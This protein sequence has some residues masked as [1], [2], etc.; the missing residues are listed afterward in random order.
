MES[1][2]NIQKFLA[3]FEILKFQISRKIE[4]LI[5]HDN[6]SDVSANDHHAQSHNAA[7]HSDITSSGAVIEAA[8][9]SAHN[10]QHDL[11][12]IPDHTGGALTDGRIIQFTANKLAN[13][14]NTNAQVSAAVTASHAQTHASS[15]HTGGADLVNHDSLTGFAANEHI[16]HTGVSITAGT[17]LT[18]GG[19]IAANRTINCSITQY[20]DSLARASIS[21]TVTGLTYTSATG[22]LS[23]TANY[24]I[25]TTT[26]ETNWTS[27]YSHISATGVSHSYIDQA[28]TIASTPTFSR[29]TLSSNPTASTQA[30]AREYIESRLQNLITNGSGLMEDNY[31]FTSFIFD[32]V[33]THGGAGSFKHIGAYIIKFSDEYVPIDGEK[34]YRFA[35]W[36]QSGDT[37]GGNYNSANHQYVGIIPYDI[38]KLAITPYYYSKVS[39]STDTTL[40]ADLNPSDT[41]ITLTD[42]TGWYEGAT[43]HMRSF[44]WYGYT[45]GKGYTYPDYTYSRTY[46]SDIWAEGGITGNVIT[47]KVPWAGS[48][49]SSGT[50]V[51]NCKSG[52]TYKYITCG[53]VIVPN[54]WTRYE[55][56]I[57]NWDTT[58]STATNLFPYGTG[59]IRLLFLN[60]YTGG[61]DPT[62]IIRWSDIWFS[63]MSSRNVEVATSTRQGVVSTTT[64]TF[65]GA[66]TFSGNLIVTGT[67]DPNGA[68]TLPTTGIT[69]AGSGSGLDADKVDGEHA[70]AIVTKAR[71]D[72]VSADH[73]ALSNIGV[74]T[75]AQ[76]DTQ[77]SANETN[78]ANNLTSINANV[79]AIGLNTTHRQATTNVHGL[80]FTGEGSGG[81]LD[82]DTVDTLH[83]SDLEPDIT[84]GTTAQYWRGDKSWQTLLGA[85]STTAYRGDRG[86]TAYN[87]SQVA[88]GNS[89]HV[90]TTENTQWDAAYTH[91]QIAGGNS[92]HVS[93]TENTNWDSAYSHISATG[94]SHSY[95][96][97][98]VTTTGTPSFNEIYVDIGGITDPSYTFD[99]DTNTG[100][101]WAGA[102]IIGF[103]CGGVMR[104]TLR[105]TYFEVKPSGDSYGIIVRDSGSSS[106][107]N[108]QNING[109]THLKDNTAA[110]LTIAGTQVNVPDHG[111][112]ATDMVVNVCYGTGNPPTANTTTIG[113]LFVKYTA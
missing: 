68:I 83:A 38:D 85:T 16:D 90:S 18:G 95:I 20:T 108:L 27:A 3:E 89:V 76:I 101:Y 21:E 93:T 111:T 82:A 45:N 30:V 94:A 70:S 15:H 106:Y 53:N 22:V 92:V 102:D 109:T 9:T 80:T 24:V 67:F 34:Y 5:S 75:H 25:P 77:M 58:G 42:A 59:Y 11:D 60:N 73:T 69:G 86:T 104:A 84:A 37:D 65:A 88:G 39:G 28:V 99:G 105:N 62:N 66:K 23:L 7:S 44:I 112:A 52:G 78:I 8:V 14:T 87:H 100:L 32:Q 6:I 110:G 36:G 56:Y 50:A 12:S 97:Q 46:A 17:G 48:A 74:Q 81:G 79:T 2:I 13:A 71:V 26:Q 49:I 29:L 91:S 1:S 96:N 33:E 35:I 98:N 113:T 103:T 43:G 72:A 41:T 31:N 51:R 19:T 61:T 4:P 64:Q 107:A 54:A 40:A 10:I 47:L 57:G 55:G 63:E